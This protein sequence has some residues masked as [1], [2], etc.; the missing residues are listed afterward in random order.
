MRL[1]VEREGYAKGQCEYV[2]C[3][4]VEEGAE[5]LAA[6]LGVSKLATKM[7]GELA[8]SSKNAPA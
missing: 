5:M 7:C 1:W 4:E 2:V 8:L 6:W 3:D